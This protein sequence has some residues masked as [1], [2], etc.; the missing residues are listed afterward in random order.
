MEDVAEIAVLFAGF[1]TNALN[2]QSV[3]VSHGWH[4]D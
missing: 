1:P 4:M 3:V 2:G